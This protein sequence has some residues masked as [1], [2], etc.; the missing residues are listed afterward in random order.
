VSRK[1]SIA[2]FIMIG[3]GTV[4]AQAPPPPGIP[5]GS[6]AG[7]KNDLEMVQKLLTTRRDY[8]TTLEQLRQLYL[9]SG[10]I[11][12]AKWAEEELRQWHRIPKQ[13]FRLELDLPPPTLTNLVN[14][15][16]AN[17]L[18]IRAMGYKDKGWGV[19]F[20]DNQRRAEILF[21]ELL[22][23]YPQ[24]NKIADSAYQL[25]DIYERP[26]Y[27]MYRRAAGYFERCYQW[28]P[29]TTFDARLRAA[30]LYDLKQLDRGRAI[31]LYREI[32]THST[33][34]RVIGEATRRLT[35]LQGTK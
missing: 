21:Q 27:K 19:E 9:Q 30:R 32:T 1:L 28:N 7:A 31:E 13:P 18:Y 14:V 25:G 33:D 12:R 23:K 6:P 29:N 3:L 2:A 34:S 35:E 5:P 20:T 16:E 8:Q 24:S 4:L 22:T 10:D 11:E 26:P 17:Q 15:P